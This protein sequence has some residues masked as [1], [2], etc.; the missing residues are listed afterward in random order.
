MQTKLQ[1]VKVCEKMPGGKNC[2]ICKNSY[3]KD[4]QVSMHR[5]PANENKRKQ[6]LKLLEQK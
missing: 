4:P 1:C 2:C 3:K 6:W 5:F